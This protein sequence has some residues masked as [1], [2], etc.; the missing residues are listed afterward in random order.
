M[1]FVVVLIMLLGAVMLIT[2]CVL[3][4]KEMLE[5]EKEWRKN[6]HEN[7]TYTSYRK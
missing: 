6:N 1:D 7:S 5:A 4:I 3:F 2:L